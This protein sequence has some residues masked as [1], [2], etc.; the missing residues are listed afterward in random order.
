MPDHVPHRDREHDVVIGRR[1]EPE[2]IASAEEDPIEWFAQ[3][4]SRW[5]VRWHAAA[6]WRAGAGY[7]IAPWRVSVT[8]DHMREAT[9]ADCPLHGW[10]AD[11]DAGC[12]CSR[13]EDEAYFLE[14]DPDHPDAIALWRCEP[15]PG[16]A[17]LLRIRRWQR[18][19]GDKRRG[20]PVLWGGSVA[21]EATWLDHAVFG[22]GP[23]GWLKGDHQ[24]RVGESQLRYCTVCAATTPHIAR[25][26]GGFCCIATRHLAWAE[27]EDLA[28][29]SI[30]ARRR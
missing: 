9:P 3:T 10:A 28:D 11:P 13:V 20:R 27:F 21:R 23:V 16:P 12:E 5:A 8:A 17:W 26:G 19:I 24:C 30:A 18:R 29:P 4:S 1:D 7:P 25:Y 6:T 14:C 15:R 2:L 22:G